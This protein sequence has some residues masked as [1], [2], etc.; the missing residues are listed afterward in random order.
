M[1]CG[2]NGRPNWGWKST[3]FTFFTYRGKKVKRVAATLQACL[4]CRNSCR[5]RAD[6]AG[7]HYPTPP[8][9]GKLGAAVAPWHTCERIAASQIA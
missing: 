2:N 9:Y 6:A 4:Y 5:A 3:R 7:T 8:P 1:N